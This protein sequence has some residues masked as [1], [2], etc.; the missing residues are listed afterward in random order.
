MSHNI[1]ITAACFTPVNQKNNK[2]DPII[3]AWI[4][5][6]VISLVETLTKFMELMSNNINRIFTHITR[7]DTDIE[8]LKKR[9]DNLEDNALL[10]KKQNQGML[11][12][13]ET[14]IPPSKTP[15]LKPMNFVDA[16]MKRQVHTPTPQSMFDPPTMNATAPAF[17]PSPMYQP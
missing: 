10:A 14:L 16:T 11:K 17:I 1:D 12:L 9:I 4:H 5:M 15:I 13:I 3:A 7:V 8:R 2:S 6:V